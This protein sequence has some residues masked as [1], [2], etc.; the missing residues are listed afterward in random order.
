VNADERRDLA[1]LLRRLL[2]AVESGEL[3]ADSPQ[4]RRLVAFLTG[5]A[6]AL[7]LADGPRPR[8]EISAAD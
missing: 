2:A 3:D 8:A 5:A 6:T 1:R 4:G 7:D